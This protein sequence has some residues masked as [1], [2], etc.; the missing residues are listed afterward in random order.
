MPIPLRWSVPTELSAEESAF[1]RKLHRIGKVYVSL[2]M[3]RSELFDE[4][5]QGS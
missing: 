2:R 4:T 5:F 1:A 3:I